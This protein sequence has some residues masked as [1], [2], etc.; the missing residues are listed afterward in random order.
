MEWGRINTAN[1]TD[2]IKDTTTMV[3]DQQAKT[4]LLPETLADDAAGGERPFKQGPSDNL[5][6]LQSNL[7]N[8]LQMIDDELMKGFVTHLDQFPAVKPDELPNGQASTSDVQMFKITELV[9]Q[10]EEFSVHKL[11]AVFHALSNRHCTLILLIQSDGDKSEFYMGVRSW[12]SSH[13]VGRMREMLENS[14]RGM[15]P[16][17]KI[18]PYRNEELKMDMEALK[19]CSVSSVTCVADY[20][21]ESEQVNNQDYIQGLEKFIDSMRGKEYTAIFLADSVGHEVLQRIKSEYENIYTQI[22]PFAD[23]QISFST[24]ASRSEASGRSE[25]Q[26]VNENEGVSQGQSDNEEHSQ[27]SGEHEDHGSSDATGTNDVQAEGET[28]TEGSADGVSDSKTDTHTEGEFESIGVSVAPEGVGVH[29]TYGTQSSDSHG[30]THGTSH[31]DS[32]SHAISKTLSHGINESHTDSVTQ[33]RSTMITDSFGHSNQYTESYNIGQ[34]FSLVDTETMTDTFGTSQGITL[35][36]K[37]RML[38]SILSR[39]DSQLERIEECESLG[40]WNFAA[41]FLG[42]SMADTETAANT[43]YSLIAGNQSGVESSAINIWEGDNPNLPV[44]MEYLT[45]FSHPAFAYERFGYDGGSKI[46]IDPS[47]LVSTNELAIHMGLPRYSV[48]GLPVVSHAVFAR[49]VLCKRQN[50]SESVCLGNVQN[51]GEETNSMVDLDLE[52]LSMH[53]FVTGSTGTGKSNTVYHMLEEARKKHVSFL[54]V[55]PAKGEYKKVFTDVPCYGTN[56]NAGRLLRMNPFAFPEKVHVL[57][58]IDGLVEIFNVCWPMYAAMPAVLKE[59]IEKAYISA[60]WDTDLSVNKKQDGLFPTFEDVLEALNQTINSS[61]YSA[62]TKSDYI[63]SLST[64]IKSLT[65]GIYGNIFVGNETEMHKIFDEDAIVDISRVRSME[66]KALIMGLL[67][68]KLQEYR[69]AQQTGMNVSLKHL[70]VLEEAHNILKKTSAEQSQESSNL[71]GK[72]VEMLTNTIAE[73]RTYGEGFIIVDQA[74]NLMDTAVIRNTNTKIV[75][76]LPEGTDREIT[77]KSMALS[78]AQITELSKLE[79]GVA[80]VYQNNWQEAVLCKIRKHERMADDCSGQPVDFMQEV[81]SE[82]KKTDSILHRLLNPPKGEKECAEL[83]RDIFRSNLSAKVRLDLIQNRTSQ[84][85]VYEWAVADF[86]NKNYDLS[87]VFRGTQRGG[88]SSYRELAD[89]MLQN[90]QPQFEGFDTGEL[91]RILYYACR[92]M[93]EMFPKNQVI[94]KMRVDFLQKEIM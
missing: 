43:Y 54:V 82:K 87:S 33:G 60:G 75:M 51:L 12:D 40:M 14:L 57:E 70:T 29:S 19:K 45:E 36:A 88:W 83:D 48:K 32:V 17:S 91:Y 68:L 81:Q 94:E 56:P 27:G 76:R 44:I 77:G 92:V 30:E 11:S 73:I 4:S 21:Q 9:Y 5:F 6:I 10:E 63:G 1:H 65:N 16:G 78:D 86:I 69:S 13:S 39:L 22:S 18:E 64:R 55:E 23:M 49:E 80:A 66:T 52:S 90:I 41:Y 67:V 42:D 37:N 25:G 3:T 84:N 53:T 34:S 89:I 50:D 7:G 2:D 59:S 74:P 79:T 72:S 15:F 8:C 85:L 47:A 46:R 61:A 38:E 35:N 58:H 28:D 20:K 62:D 31:T 71:Q 93:H 26:T 24:N